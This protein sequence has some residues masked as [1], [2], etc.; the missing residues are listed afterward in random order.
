MSDI[1]LEY[2]LDGYHLI[3][4]NIDSYDALTV[5]LEQ[6]RAEA[7]K[8]FHAVF[9]VDIVT[10]NVGR[11]SIGLSD[12]SILMYT[13]DDLEEPRTSMGD[14]TAQGET[15]FYLGD[16]SLMSDKYIIPYVKAMEVVK[17]W[18]D[19]GQMGNILEWTNELF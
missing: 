14:R 7:A 1:Y 10:R 8:L 12:R 11:L 5:Q 17:N 4:M 3:R 19:E 13:S 2:C 6:I 16:Y 18:I 9:C 15:M